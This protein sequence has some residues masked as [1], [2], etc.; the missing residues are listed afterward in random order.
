MTEEETEAQTSEVSACGVADLRS[1]GF[2]HDILQL[3]CNREGSVQCREEGALMGGAW[4]LGDPEEG[5]SNPARLEG[6]G[7]SGG[8]LGGGDG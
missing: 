4:G 8:L 7:S 1:H 5:V 6:E 3:M 2:H